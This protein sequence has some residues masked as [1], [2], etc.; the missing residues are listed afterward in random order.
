MEVVPGG[1]EGCSG[2]G[3]VASERKGSGPH[4]LHL[5]VNRSGSD[6]SPEVGTGE[7]C[8]VE[9]GSALPVLGVEVGEGGSGVG[10]ELEVTTG[11]REITQLWNRLVPSNRGVTIVLDSPRCKRAG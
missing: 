10:G 1:S 4:R 9:G 2:L 8:G 6:R 3:M 5:G 11:H 7:V